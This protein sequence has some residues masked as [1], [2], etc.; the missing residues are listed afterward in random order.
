MV[1]WVGRTTGFVVKIDDLYQGKGVLMAT[2]LHPGLRKAIVRVANPDEA[3]IMM[4][5]TSSFYILGQH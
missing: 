4:N 5:L 2:N 3:R 1:C